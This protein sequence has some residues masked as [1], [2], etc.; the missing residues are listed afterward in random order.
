MY[1]VLLT[2]GMAV[3]NIILTSG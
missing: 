1:Y 2:C 3:V